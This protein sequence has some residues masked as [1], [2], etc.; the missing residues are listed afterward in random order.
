MIQTLFGSLEQPER[1]SLFDRMRDAVSRT[2][3]NMGERIDSVLAMA[4]TVDESALEELEMSL[5]ASDIGVATSAEI[6][7]NLRERAKRQQI[8]DA[9]RCPGSGRGA[10]RWDAGSPRP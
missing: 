5:I 2:R 1:K 3:E 7:D 9:V 10:F 4:R 8:R 6:V